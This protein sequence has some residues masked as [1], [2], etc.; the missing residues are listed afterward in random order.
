VPRLSTFAALVVAGMPGVA[1]AQATLTLDQAVGDALSRNRSLQTARSHALEATFGTQEAQSGFLPRV[2]VSE[3]WQRGDQPVFVFSSLLSARQFAASNFAIESLN[4]P[5][6]TGFFRTTVGVEQMLFDGGRQRANATAA[7]LQRD[8]A[9]H[10]ADQSANDVKLA[11]AQAYGRVF[12]AQASRRAAE[13]GV[14]SAVEDLA[15]AERRRDAGMATEADVLSLRVHRAD[16]EQ[17]VIQAD[18]DAAIAKAELNHLMGSPI[19]SDYL[20]VEP[21]VR[22]PETPDRT[23]LI[24]A[25]LA[26]RPSLKVSE[27]ATALAE[28]VR[29]STRDALIPHVS[30]QGAVEI[31]GTSFNDRASSWLFGGELR[32]TMSTGGAELSRLKAATEAASRARTEQEDARAMVEVEVVSAMKRL[33][34]ARARQTASAAA[35]EQAR[36]SQ[37]IIRDRF[38][39]GIAGTDEVLRAST[40]VLEADARRTAAMIDGVIA[41]AMLDRAV[42][43]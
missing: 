6:P 21:P 16:L 33:D 43:R 40:A 5:N 4:H 19:D 41:E 42:G 20:V 8:M 38:D 35:V 24:A 34:T 7:S 15:R 12:T 13:A 27:A 3:S 23:T 29:R 9:T 39:A 10:E 11:V 14:E 26:G 28:T 31:A 25:A 17:R 2:T 30:A 22:A 18:G 32:W 36:E 37:R 1:L